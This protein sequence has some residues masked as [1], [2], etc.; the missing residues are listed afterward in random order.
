MRR[1]DFVTAWP[2]L[3][4]LLMALVEFGQVWFYPGG[5]G[6]VEVTR[7]FGGAFRMTLWIA[8]VAAVTAHLGRRGAVPMAR[9][10]WPFAAFIGWGAVV[11]LLWSVDRV[12]GVRALVFWSLAAG[13]AAAAGDAL[14]PDRLARGVTLLFGTVVGA[15]LLLAVALPGAAHTLYGDEMLVRGLFPHKNQFGWYAAIGLLWTWTLR[16]EVGQRVVWAVVPVLLAGLLVADSITAQVIAVAAA[17]YVIAVRLSQRLFRDGARAALAMMTA[18][19]LAGLVVVALGPTLLG[20]LGRD[21]TLTG[22]TQV[23][24]HYLGYVQER[25]L[26]GYG[27]GIFST[28]TDMNVDI[29]GTVPGYERE[30]LH[31]PHNV[32][33]GIAG[34]TGLL[35]V[36]AFL[37]AQLHL[38]FVAPFRMVSPWQ[39][40]AGTLAFAILVAGLA[41]TRDGYA[42][43][44][45]TVALLAARASA[46]RREPVAMR[47]RKPAPQA[48]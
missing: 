4:V 44:V 43:G 31:S 5:E 23:W 36:L 25:S 28:I 20:A 35:G 2:F 22:R 10:L 37:A 15:S 42:P 30:G 19:L 8:A 41:E 34:E 13:L 29:G 21:P 48:V 33:I 16:R 3:V 11:L 38:A 46:L 45:A 32:Y 24:R 47:A 26:T 12:I 14:A 40:L 39:R 17:G 18:T 9:A 7:T 1:G 6:G 27:T